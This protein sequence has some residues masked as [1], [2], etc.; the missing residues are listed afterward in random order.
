[1]RA[2]IASLPE[3]DIVEIDLST[4]GRAI[5]K[6]ASVLAGHGGWRGRD[7]EEERDAAREAKYRRQ[8]VD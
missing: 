1:M 5:A 6:L 7:L 8:D 4:H 3:Q 2:V